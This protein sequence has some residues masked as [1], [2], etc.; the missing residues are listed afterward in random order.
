[1]TYQMF[2]EKFIQISYNMELFAV[3]WDCVFGIT[4]VY[5][6]DVR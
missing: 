1:M 6:L 3:G 4:T 5:G 2:V